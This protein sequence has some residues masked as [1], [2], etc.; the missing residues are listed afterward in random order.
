MTKRSTK[1]ALLLSALSLILCVSMLIGST[2]AWFTDSV[3]S[4]NNKIQS[5]TLQIDLEMLVKNPDN[6]TSWKSIKEDNA[7]IF[8]YSNWEPGYIDSKVLKVEN[9]GTLAL[10]WVAQF[11]S[12][13]SL[14]ILADAIDVYVLPSA[15]EIGFPGRSLT[16]YENKGTLR[17]FLNTISQTTY[18]TLMPAGDADGKD[19]A[20]LGIA[21]KM[22]EDAGN[23]YQGLDLGGSFDIKIFATQLNSEVDSFDKD[24]DIKSEYDG[25]GSAATPIDQAA[26]PNAVEIDVPNLNTENPTDKIASVTVPKDAIDSE[27]EE[28]QINVTKS[29]YE[30]NITV[31]AGQEKLAYDVEVIGLKAGNTTDV[32]VKIQI[33]PNLDPATVKIYHY[34]TEIPCTYD[35][36]TGYVTFE[37]ATFSPFTIVYDAESEYVAP[38]VDEESV[39]PTATV[40]EYALANTPGYSDD[41]EVVWGGL[42]GFAPDYTVDADP[43][44]EAAYEFICNQTGDEAAASDYANW[45]CDFFVKLDG[46]LGA[47]QIFLGGNYGDF[48]WIGFH[49]GDLTLGA[50][51]YV[52]LLSLVSAPWTY[53]SVATYVGDFVCG[54]GDVNDALAGQT[55]TV[56]LRLIDPSKVDTDDPEWWSQEK[57]TADKYIVVNSTTHTFVEGEYVTN[58]EDLQNALDNAEDGDTIV[59]GED[60]DLTEGLV[61]GG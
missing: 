59:L 40:A 54:V 10:K 19:V 1:Q 37:S 57:L 31:A 48:G 42:G 22:R 17:S 50:N 5:G 38:E 45:Y 14:S 60:I 13:K 24:Y 20:Y 47:N 15:T 43:K 36:S 9:E 3:T 16:G 52:P 18:G 6:S 44:L 34:D 33:G 32:K 51:T 55:F 2:F 23:I 35:P 53:T 4:S 8:N 7:P 12:K 39:V 58:A 29:D 46:D 56:E 61:I 26:L 28:I 49:N 27:S 30:A 11:V 21:L 41:P 25:F